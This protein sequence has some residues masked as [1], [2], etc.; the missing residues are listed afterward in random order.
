MPRE[1]SALWPAITLAGLL[2]LANLLANRAREVYPGPQPKDRVPSILIGDEACDLIRVNAGRADFMDVWKIVNC[3]R[4][5][6]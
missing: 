2:I 4:I 6:R 3:R 5:T 1:M